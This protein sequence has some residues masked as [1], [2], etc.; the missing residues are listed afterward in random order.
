MIT[1][2]RRSRLL[3]IVQ[4]QGFASLPDLAGALEVSE[5]TVRRD[6][7]QL[8]NEG[9]AKRTHGGAF[10]TGPSPN[11]VHFRHQKAA[12][13]DKKKA[14]AEI[15]AGL[16]EDSDTVLL[17]GGSTTYELAQRLVARPLQIVTNSLPVAN[18]FNSSPNI[19]LVVIGGYVHPRSGAIQ[20][21]YAVQMLESLRVRKAVISAAGVHVQGLYNSN[22]LLVNTQ[23]AMIRSA[24]EVIVVADSTKF[25]HQSLA[26]ICDLSEVHHFVVDEALTPEWRD[27]ITSAGAR[28]HLA[29]A[30]ETLPDL[31]PP[32]SDPSP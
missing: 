4:R 24:E 16:I 26:H 3:E 5:S 12:Q 10:Y 13:W 25:G 6:L 31:R 11:L 8:E 17:D 28:L 19:D 32:T 9:A 20:G 2:D 1:T 30:H 7:A 15:A 29:A 18:L 14:I 21:D 27:R 22:L 23:R